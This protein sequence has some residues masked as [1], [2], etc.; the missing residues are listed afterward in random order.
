MMDEQMSDPAF[1][2]AVR[3]ARKSHP[4][5]VA[6]VAR[7][8]LS[9]KDVADWERNMD[10]DIARRAAARASARADS[11]TDE[12]TLQWG[13][14][15]VTVGLSTEWLNGATCSVAGAYDAS[16]GRYV[17]RVHGPPEAV[18]KCGGMAL[19]KRDNLVCE[20]W[21][22]PRVDPTTHWVDEFGWV[23]SK[24]VKYGQQCPRSHEVVCNGA[25]GP[26]IGACSVCDEAEAPDVLSC[27]GGCGYC[28]CIECRD[29]L[30]Q[31]QASN[32]S[33]SSAAIAN[34]DEFPMLV[35][36]QLML[37]LSLYFQA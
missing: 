13:Q 26:Q 24:A 17:L 19:L 9:E 10:E 20:T 2:K 6:M 8:G 14:R 23:C 25:T 32:T 11:Q 15:V 4:N 1:A 3:N 21:S 35:S 31:Q 12:A 27:C 18:R 36:L 16:S 5:Y 22:K 34:S 28:V 33:P 7:L 37:H 29:V 30:M